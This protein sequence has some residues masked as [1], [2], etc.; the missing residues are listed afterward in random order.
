MHV[1]VAPRPRALHND[2]Q[3]FNIALVGGRWTGPRMLLQ[4]GKTALDPESGL[5][6]CKIGIP[7]VLCYIK[8]DIFQLRELQGKMAHARINF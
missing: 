2:Q 7:W 3:C 6:G 4:P 8:I 1:L 5:L